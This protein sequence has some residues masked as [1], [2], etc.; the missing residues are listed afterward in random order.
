MKRLILFTVLLFSCL[1]PGLQTLSQQNRSCDLG[2]TMNPTFSKSSVLDSILR[3]YAPVIL[4][5]VSLAVYTEREGWWAGSA[6]YASLEKKVPM[7]TCHVQYIQSV[8]KMYMAVEILQLKEQG[9]LDLDAQVTKYLPAKYAK[10]I[11]DAD[12]ITIRML[13]NHTSGIPEYNDEPGF[14][15]RVMMHPSDNFT[16]EDCFHAIAGRQLLFAPGSRYSYSNTN[17]LVLAAIGDAIT[18]DH[19]AYIRKHLF[20]K[21][22]LKNSF[23]DRGNQYLNGLHLP[24]SYWDILNC[25]NAANITVLQKMTVACSKGDD[26]IVCTPADAVLF[27]RGLFDGKLLN[28][29]S[30]EEM[31]HFVKDKNGKDKYGM[32]MFSLDLGG[33][34]AYG[35]G[36]GGVGSGCGL[37]YVPSHKTYLFIAT[38]LG[39][40][41]DGK[42]PAKADAM[43]TEILMALLQ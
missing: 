33:L 10:C 15:S 27:L 21:L 12:M 37:I 34:T 39:V 8:T 2:I 11:Q 13:L 18:G 35:H 4:P 20:E 42:L 38:N 17:Y 14:V 40:L 7:E 28:T 30:M 29:S 26:G 23:Y 41:V 5:G 22:Q 6:G 36:G 24:E 1:A 16:S 32:G 31:M 25:G 43:K 3:K 19:A 9:L